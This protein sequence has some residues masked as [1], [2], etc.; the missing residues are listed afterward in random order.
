L[1]KRALVTILVGLAL[2]LIAATIRSGWLYLTASVLFSLVVIGVI[3]GW[4]AVRKIE[5]TREAPR[6]VFEREPFEVAVHVANNGHADRHLVKV[7]DLQFP[8]SGG[9]GFVAKIRAQRAEFKEFMMTGKASARRA[10]DRDE[11]VRTVVVEDLPG[12]TDVEARY[13]MEAPRRGVYEPAEMRVSSGGVFGSAEIGHKSRTGGRITV[14]PR[15]Y[16]IDAFTF[17][18]HAHVTPVEPLEWS[19][20]G[21]G[22]D[23]YGIREYARGDSLRHIH[24]PSSARHG[25]LIVKEYE[26]ELKPSMVMAIALWEPAFGTKDLNSLEDG[27][28]A[29]ASIISLQEEMGSLPLLVLPDGDTFE[30]VERPTLYGCLDALAGYGG[31]KRRVDAAGALSQSLGVARASMFP[32]TAMV[33]I[34]NAAPDSVASALASERARDGGS[35]VLAI[36]DA[37]GSR[38]KEE[39][40]DEAPWLAG[41]VGTGMDL[42][43]ITPGRGIERC[44][45]EPLNITG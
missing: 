43:A 19:R 30:P 15:I 41:F 45:N 5:V 31:L 16:P 18:P 1:T 9:R 24:W 36:D 42:Y 38:W 17:M 23:Y 35:L 32:G 8:G 14:F 10:V 3:S 22:Q 6:E 25:K 11:T 40:L 28:R 34:T 21:I 12:G 39:W 4:V 33:L 20:K 7:K 37:Y 13:E 27:L 44:L 26:Q 2:L 29:A